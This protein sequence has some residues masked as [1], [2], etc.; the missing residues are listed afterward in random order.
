MNMPERVIFVSDWHL[1]PEHTAKTD[2]FVRFVDE[3]CAGAGRVF[4]LG[5]LFNAWVGPRHVAM[6]GHAAALDALKR[7]AESG[8]VVVVLRGNRDFLLDRRT[9][10]PYGLELSPGAWRGEAGGRRLMLSHGDELT[11]DDRLHKA[12]RALTGN[13]PLSTFVKLLPLCASGA[14]AAGYR[15]LSANRRSRRKRKKLYPDERRVSAAFDDGA[16]IV[17]IGHWHEPKLET[18]V[19]GFTGKT[20][21]M[22][23]E[24]TESAAVY[25]ELSDGMITLERLPEPDAGFRTGDAAPT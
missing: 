14:L 19:F 17:V 15:W 23:G 12:A 7:L 13:F 1:P 3:V 11:E 20:F 4:V 16:D 5:D 9:V 2:A 8:T 22:L 21:V 6:P 18:D 25:A 10:R 24:C